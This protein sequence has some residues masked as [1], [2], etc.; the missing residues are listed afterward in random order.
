MR[1]WIKEV[2]PD[3]WKESI[4][5]PVHRKGDRSDYN[6]CQVHRQTKLLGMDHQFGLDVTHQL[7]IEL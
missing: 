4:I 3:Q 1:L 7:L 6:K 2:L 5:V